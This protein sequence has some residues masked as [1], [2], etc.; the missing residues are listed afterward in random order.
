MRQAVAFVAVAVVALAG[1]QG[2]YS[3]KAEKVRDPAPIKP[4]ATV[5]GEGETEAVVYNENPCPIRLS[6]ALPSKKKTVSTE[7][8]T[9]EGDQKF[10]KIDAAPTASAKTVLL[11]DSL[12]KYRRALVDDPFSAEAT[13]K[14]ALAYDKANYKSCAL[15]L[16]G[17][18]AQLAEHPKYA[19]AANQRIDEVVDQPTYFKGYRPQAVSAVGR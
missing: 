13:L 16:L 5:P 19:P 9:A 17:R 10:E 12:D 4:P 15:S 14:L 18:L 8:L 11:L 7:T 3:G 2:M 1:C 6:A